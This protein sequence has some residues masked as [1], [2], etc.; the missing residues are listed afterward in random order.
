MGYLDGMAIQE[1]M[2]KMKCLVTLEEM[3]SLVEML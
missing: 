3:A 2:E 1:Q